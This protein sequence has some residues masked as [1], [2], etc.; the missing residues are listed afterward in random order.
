[1]TGLHRHG[2]SLT[3]IDV[4]MHA[5]PGYDGL[6]SYLHA[7]QRYAERSRRLE[8]HAIVPAGRELHFAGWHELPASGQSVLSFKGR[9]AAMRQLLHELAPDVI[10]LHGPFEPAQHVIPAARMTDARIIAVSHHQAPPAPYAVA[11][12]MARWGVQRREALALRGI[13][14]PIRPSPPACRCSEA[15]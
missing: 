9:N 15:L 1:L 8:H 5:G 6:A 11:R 10:V 2:G 12:A 4:A 14:P 3:V 13:E 7:K